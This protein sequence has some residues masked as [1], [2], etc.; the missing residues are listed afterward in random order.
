M[1][2]EVKID[3]FDTTQRDGAQS[4]PEHHQFA[5][6]SKPYISDRIATLGADVIEAGFPATAGDGEEV[7]RVAQSVGQRS[8]EVQ[9]W[10]N[11]EVVGQS[12]ATPVITGLSRAT[13]GDIE[14]TWQS[15]C[16][17]NR[18]RI[19]TFIPTD[20][21]HMQERF[22]DKTSKEIMRMGQEA[23]KFAKTLTEGHPDVTIE[24]SAEAAS[25]TDLRFLET[26]VKTMLYEGADIINVPDTVGQRDPVWMYRFYRQAIKWVHSVNPD[27]ITSGHNH[28]DLGQAVSNTNMLL[29]AAVDHAKDTNSSVAIQLETTITGIGERAGNADVFPVVA[30]L[31]RFTPDIDIPIRWRFNPGQSVDTAKSVMAEAGLEV[32]RQSPIVGSDINRHRSGGHSDGIIKGGHRLYTPFDPTFWGHESEAIHEDGKYQGSRGR[33]AIVATV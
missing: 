5:D 4:L 31:F 17:A 11:G 21:E 22:P 14:A 32:P 23:I 6:D 10:R 28:N 26:V 15:V 1:S 13:S 30:G 25:T 19:H 29:H 9:T 2:A 24:F 12:L 7:T 27:A 3:I 16:Q 8:Y 33:S 18:A 20:S